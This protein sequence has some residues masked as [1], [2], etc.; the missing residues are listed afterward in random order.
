M[1][2]TSPFNERFTIITDQKPAPAVTAAIKNAGA[3]LTVAPK[4]PA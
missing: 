2:L 4:S 1:S 3:Q